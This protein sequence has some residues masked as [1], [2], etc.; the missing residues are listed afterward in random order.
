MVR[1]LKKYLDTIRKRYPVR[2]NA[3]KSM[4]TDFVKVVNT[5]IYQQT[6]RSVKNRRLKMR[7]KKLIDRVI[8]VIYL[9]LIFIII[10]GLLILA[11]MV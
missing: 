7:K 2:T 1:S 9:P 11:S 6:Q 5:L 4:K 8:D 10:Y 3:L